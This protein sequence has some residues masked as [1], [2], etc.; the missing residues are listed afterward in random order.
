MLP[1]NGTVIGC[2]GECVD[3]WHENISVG[4]GVVCFSNIL[5]GDGSGKG[6]DDDDGDGG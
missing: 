1:C 5:G 2:T 4:T 6:D 3:G